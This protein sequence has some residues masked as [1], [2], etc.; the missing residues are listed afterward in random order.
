MQRFGLAGWRSSR[1][2]RP[3][4]AHRVAFGVAAVTLLVAALPHSAAAHGGGPSPTKTRNS[5]PT[6]VITSPTAGAS[7][8]GAFTAS[9][10][11]SDAGAV[12]SVTVAVDGGAA[13][14]ATG[15]TAWSFALDA[16][17]LGAGSHTL[18]A[19]ATDAAGLSA[20]ASVTFAVAASPPPP[21]APPTVSIT[22]PSAAAVVGGPFTVAGTAASGS[23]VTQVAVQIDDGPLSVAAGTASWNVS[24]SAAGLTDGPHSVTAWVSDST[25]RSAVS[26]VQ[27][28]VRNTPAC[29]PVAGQATISGSLFEDMNRDGVLDAGDVPIGGIGIYFFDAAGNYQGAVATNAAGAYTSMPLAGGTYSVEL[30]T[31]WWPTMYTTWI[32]DTTGSLTDVATTCASGATTLNFGLRQI[33]RSSDANAPVSAFTGPNGLTVESY[34]DVVSARS[35]F[36][37]LM[38]GTLI[39]PE[40]AYETVRFDLSSTTT[41]S[42]SCASVNGVYVS[43]SSYSYIS[44]V[45]WLAEGDFPLFF[46]YGNHWNTYYTYLKHAASWSD[47]Y[48]E[49]GVA[50][51]PLLGSGQAWSIEMLTDDWR[52]LFG[53][54]TAAAVNPLNGSIAPAPQVA[55][56]S[57]WLATTYRGM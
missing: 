23:T 48:T 24:L 1:R 19:R 26:G 9:G 55:G 27:L 32:P 57:T 46:E 14:A 31:S 36:D 54:P 25:G 50:G 11:A 3:R 35:L 10:T 4:S 45:T 33:V 16:N 41:T 13:R 34:D 5:P 28:E 56:L 6:V 49:R 47:Y 21:P 42:S 30:Q 52:Q 38:T 15:T 22:S 8:S 18:T 39:G 17:A 20:T 40:A 44:L 51:N 53:S 29:S 2:L 7:M 37:D 12:A 43:C